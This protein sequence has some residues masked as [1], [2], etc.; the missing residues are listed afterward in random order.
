MKFLEYSTLKGPKAEAK[1]LDV[2][3][4]KIDYESVYKLT[5]LGA[6]R[7]SAMG[8][9]DKMIALH[10]GKFSIVAAEQDNEVFVWIVGF[11][12]NGE[13][14][15]TSPIQSVRKTKAGFRI[16]TENSLYLLSEM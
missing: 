5:K 15:K 10:K 3:L 16:E 9:P 6:K 1:A 12:I 2:G 7:A 4:D 8:Y 13:S 11:W 14:F